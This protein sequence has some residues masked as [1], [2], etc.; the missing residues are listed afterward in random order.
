MLMMLLQEE[1]GASS[2]D[3]WVEV[4]IEPNNLNVQGA[5][6]TAFSWA[7]TGIVIAVLITGSMAALK[8]F[9][10]ERAAL[11]DKRWKLA[12]VTGFMA[13]GLLIAFIPLLAIYYLSMNF[14]LIL[15]VQGFFKGVIFAWVIYLLAMLAS[16]L[17]APWSRTDYG[18]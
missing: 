6:E 11:K 10:K 3:K 12:K 7:M 18:L 9:L 13:A 14:T 8:W 16:D 1:A 17:I 2:L 15:G 5:H 4:F